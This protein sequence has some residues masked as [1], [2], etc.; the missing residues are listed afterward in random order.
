MKKFLCIALMLCLVQVKAQL[1]FYTTTNYS[2]G[3]NTNTKNITTGDFNGDGKI[4]LAL[5]IVTPSMV[6]ILLNDGTGHFPTAN[7]FTTNSQPYSICS[8]DFNNDNKA[9]IAVA[10][11][12][13]TFKGF[14][15][16]LGNGAGSLGA[17]SGYSVGTNPAEIATADFNNDGKKDIAITDVNAAPSGAVPVYLGNGSGGFTLHTTLSTGSG[18][19]S[20]HPTDI[21]CTDVTGDNKVDFVV[22]C[23]DASNKVYIFAGD[24]AGGAATPYAYIVGSGSTYNQMGLAISDLNGDGKKDIV[25]A[26]GSAGTVSVLLN[27]SAGTGSFTSNSYTAGNNSSAVVCADFDND[28]DNDIAVVNSSNNQ[29][30]IL[31]NNGLGVFSAASAST[32]FAVDVSPVQMVTAD[33]D[34][35]GK[36]DI[37]TANEST[38]SDDASVLLN[39]L[40]GAIAITGTTTICAGTSTT[41]TASGTDIF[42]WSTNAGSATTASVSVTPS[43]T[44]TYTV[45]GNNTNC[46]VTATQTVSVQVNALPTINISASPNY[47]C[48]ANPVTLTASGASTYTWSNGI[49][50]GVAFTPTGVATYTVNATDAN[51]CKNT[52]T[53]TIGLSVPQVPQICLV[54]TD[55]VTF[56]NY[57]II[58]WDKTQYTN[59]DSFFIYRYEALPNS[60]IK[61]G[62]VPGDSSH[63]MDTT[64]HVYGAN[65]GDPN[66]T[67]YK[68]TLA[69]K[70][71]CG[72]VGQQS[73]YHETVFLQDQ[74]NSNFNLNPY[75]MGAGQTNPVT[76][77]AL[78]KDASGTGNN[79]TYVT[80]ITSTSGTD[81]GYT[82]TAVYRVDILGFNCVVNQRLANGGNANPYVARQKSHSNTSR[83]TGTTGINQNQNNAIHIYPNPSSG[84]FVIETSTGEKQIVQAF[85]VNGNLVLTETIN[86]KSLIDASCLSNGVY[87]ITITGST[88]TVNKRLVVVK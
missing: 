24:G 40:P 32:A 77:Y 9:D 69:I 85:D 37:A 88:G 84:N 27:N 66:Y 2:V 4:D 17:A 5:A 81:P 14:S 29:I 16:M 41:L 8:A 62:A 79:F 82:S 22:A 78:F 61:I 51:N 31:L 12:G 86:G 70:D 36:P 59:V 52:A 75:T 60:Y 48:N 74:H 30:A 26:N 63:W 49:T 13:S 6:S 20:V 35:N 28:G 56:Y 19:V 67:S 76:G 44:A 23:E 18:T 87:N 53:V 73:P 39:S 46:T 7:T 38:S 68:Y 3:T 54:T 57:N 55:S 58:Y 45:T 50:N 33:F 15:V 65:D 21:I 43:V 80:T 83:I 42:N 64:R 34:A 47:V 1:C 71:S 11:N 25:S 72:N 10:N